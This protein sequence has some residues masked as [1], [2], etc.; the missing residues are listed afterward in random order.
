M[1]KLIFKFIAL[2]LVLPL[3]AHCVIF[4]HIT[5]SYSYNGGVYYNAVIDYWDENDSTPNPCYN[6]TACKISFN[7]VHSENGEGG[8]PEKEAIPNAYKYATIGEL[9]TEFKKKW[10]L[11]YSL[12]IYH[13]GPI[14]FR[15]CAGIFYNG[16]GTKLLPNSICK[17]APPQELICTLTGDT[18]LEH[19]NL[20]KGA[21]AGHKT[22]TT[23]KIS[24]NMSA[25]LSVYSY[26]SGTDNIQLSN[27][28]SLE[29]EITLNGMNG[30]QGVDIEV[31]LN[32]DSS[33]NITSTLIQ[34][35][36]LTEGVFHGSGII[37]LFYN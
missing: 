28:G 25:L 11:P 7:H 20:L 16:D 36:E 5:S 13:G 10:G 2:L 3:N 37:S 4:S 33:I 24:C 17:A 9:G 6:L 26:G 30:K 23:L 35:G 31:K 12:T 27:D 22:S 15:E 18:N 32:S 34:H 8:T 19:G 14:N 21:V 29:S 1:N